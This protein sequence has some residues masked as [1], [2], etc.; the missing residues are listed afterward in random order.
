MRFLDIAKSVILTL[1][2]LSG[3]NTGEKEKQIET[4][5]HAK[6]V[7][8]DITQI[9]ETNSPLKL[10]RFADSISYI[11]LSDDDFLIKAF[12]AKIKIVEDALFIFDYFGV[13]KFNLQGKFLKKLVDGSNAQAY[14]LSSTAFNKKENYFTLIPTPVNN[15]YLQN[16]QNMNY[17]LDGVYLGKTERNFDNSYKQIEA[18]FKDYCLYRMEAVVSPGSQVNRLGPF[19][20]YAEDIKTDSVVYAYPNP[21]AEDNYLFRHS[22]DFAPA[23]M[24]FISIDSVLWF[25]HFAI[26]TVYSTR[27]FVAIHPRYIFKTD[28]SFM[29]IDEYT[30][31]KNGL[32]ADDKVSSINKIWGIL[33][34]PATDEILFTSINNR[35]AI[36][37]KYGKTTGSTGRTVIND[38]DKYLKE[39]EFSHHLIQRKFFME[40]NYL[41][42]LIEANKFFE[43]GCKPPFM[44]LT[45]NSNPVVMKIKLKT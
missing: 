11:R 36:A 7:I 12:S 4:D 13:Y 35:I 6:P 26:D 38:I 15:S 31:L 23:N 16:I 32:L 33:P 44:D 3:C 19:L 22:S 18:Y 14:A 25:K 28:T 24:N 10:S 21:K 1:F 41:Y 30:Q 29:N 39:V 20:F 9:K 43:E 27:D 17:S 5:N 40:N 42:L 34:L 2:F 45:K 8:I 37:D